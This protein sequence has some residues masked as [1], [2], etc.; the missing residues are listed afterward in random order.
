MNLS[1]SDIVP[2]LR[3]TAPSQVEPIASDT[4]LPDAWWQALPLDRACLI[5]GTAQVAA[6]LADLSMACWGHLPLGDILP[7]IRLTDPEQSLRVPETREAVHALFTSVLSRLLASEAQPGRE[8]ASVPAQPAKPDRP[9]PELIDE[10]FAALDD[11]QRA[12]AKDRVYAERRVTLDE[13]AQRFSVTRERIRQI[14]RD[15]RDHVQARLAAPEATPLAAHLA[16]LRGRLG[17]AV[18]AD[19]LAAAVPWH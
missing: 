8:A 14:E 5:V 17:S 6:R 3:W 16:W 12:I 19:D 18:P 7:L 9:I 11:R 4:R 15:L 13:L 1:L 2:P 10:I